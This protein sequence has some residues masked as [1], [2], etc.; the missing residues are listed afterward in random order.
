[1][2]PR[3]AVLIDA[4]NMSSR[5]WP[6][7]R[8]KIEGLGHVSV[9]RVFG[10]LAEERLASW[11]KIA[12]DEALQPVMQFS[13]PN[14]CDIALT[15]S[16]MDLLYSSKLEGICLVS[17][18]G[19]FTPLVHRLKAGGLKV[20]GFGN[21]KSSPGLVKACTGFVKLAELAKPIGVAKAA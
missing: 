18:D 12:E 17:S 15:V 10:N 14:A 1:M 11:L 6:K 4:E 13:G 20:H 5:H 3:L 21:A 2:Q 19:D 9:C 8:E 16:A 7:I